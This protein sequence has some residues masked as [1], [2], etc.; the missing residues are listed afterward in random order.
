MQITT[1]KKSF[2]RDYSENSH[3]LNI[4]CGLLISFMVYCCIIFS[5]NDVHYQD[6]GALQILSH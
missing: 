1:Q 4:R 2:I 6:L 3:V 5:Y